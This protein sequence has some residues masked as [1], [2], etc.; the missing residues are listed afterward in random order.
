[1]LPVMVRCALELC[2]LEALKFG[3]FLRTRG[4]LVTGVRA[5]VAPAGLFGVAG[6]LQ[7]DTSRGS[8]S[9]AQG[10]AIRSTLSPNIWSCA[11]N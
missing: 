11:H 8:A 7:R 5:S 4:G 2:T 3:A 1:M 9:E 10:W 6:A